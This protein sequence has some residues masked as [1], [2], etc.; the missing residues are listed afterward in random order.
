MSEFADCVHV[1]HTPHARTAC[2]HR[3]HAP[4]A[5]TACTHR[6]HTPHACTACTHRMHVLHAFSCSLQAQGFSRL[7][8][9]RAKADVACPAFCSDCGEEV[10]VRPLG[11]SIMHACHPSYSTNVSISRRLLRKRVDMLFLMEPIKDGADDTGCLY[12][13]AQSDSIC[14]Y[15]M[16]VVRLGANI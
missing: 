15:S 4:H 9:L 14:S 12:S 7:L 10:H 8:P 16:H 3:M 1:L 2:T 5:H 6:V 13:Y 11:S